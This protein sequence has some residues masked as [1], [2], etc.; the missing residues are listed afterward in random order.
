MF[1]KLRLRDDIE[2]TLIQNRMLVLSS[3]ILI[4]NIWLLFDE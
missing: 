3:N 1:W 4:S 2:F